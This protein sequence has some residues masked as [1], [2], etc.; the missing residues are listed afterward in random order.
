MQSIGKGDMRM[1]L[2][3]KLKESLS[4]TRESL[5]GR[6]DE[7]VTAYVEL[8]E[9][10]YE[11]LTDI[12]I[13]ADV[14]MKTTELAVSQLRKKC[15]TEKIG[16]PK[17]AREELKK[18]LV[19]IMG[20]EPM[21]LESPMVLLIIGVNGV[22]KTTSIGK[23]ASRM[24]TVG[25]RV[26]LC[27]ADTFRAAAADQLTI[28]AQRADV[29]IIKQHE[30]ADPAAVVFDGIQAAKG[31]HADVL[32]VD[33]A[34]RLHNKAHL[35]EELKKISRVVEREYPQAK[36]KALLVIDATTGQNGLSQA[37]TFRE[38]TDLDGIVL[39]KLDGTAKGG[40][41]IAIRHELGL[42]VRYIGVG[43]Q[44]DD[45]QPFDAREFIDAIF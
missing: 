8:D 33:T 15:Q 9:D 22:G 26:V 11:D 43:E 34:G 37:A 39:T 19:D 20:S 29:P 13:M 1:G 16:D 23:L 36:M 27:A 24:K 7:L 17:Q 38:V 5:S 6:M 44:L 3:N 10:F 28:W 25:R 32:I 2:F 18:I 30:G 42:P 35:M 40:I 45:L 4:R 12:L 14:G 41:A 21:R 31:R